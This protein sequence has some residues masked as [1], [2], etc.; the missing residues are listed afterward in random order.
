VLAAGVGTYF[1]LQARSAWQTRD[2]HCSGGRCDDQAV[3]AWR[4]ATRHA[5]FA[6]ASFLAAAVFSGVGLYLV[7]SV[8]ASPADEVSLRFSPTSAS[9]AEL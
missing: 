7:L 5:A 9:E 6:D 8:P 2:R 1:G 4:D 3:D